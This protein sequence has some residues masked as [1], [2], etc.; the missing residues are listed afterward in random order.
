MRRNFRRRRQARSR[1]GDQS[2]TARGAILR[3]S[4]RGR[5]HRARRLCISRRTDRGSSHS[6]SQVRNSWNVRL[7][8]RLEVADVVIWVVGNGSTLRFEVAA[9]DACSETQG[10]PLGIRGWKRIHGAVDGVAKPC[11]IDV[12]GVAAFRAGLRLAGVERRV[13]LCDGGRGYR[14]RR[15]N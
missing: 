2:T 11:S 3:R 6:H 13:H 9:L 15:A 5:R 7:R 1:R 4:F 14:G 10:Q 12:D 8:S